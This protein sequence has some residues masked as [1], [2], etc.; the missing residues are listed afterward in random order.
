MG[1]YNEIQ[2]GR[3]NRLVQK[4]LSLKGPASLVSA[5][6]VL[7]FH[8]PLFHGKENRYLEAWE[9]FAGVAIIP[10]QGVGNLSVLQLRNDITT[11]VI[12]VVESL[13]P[14]TS[15]AAATGTWFVREVNVT[16]VALATAMVST[17]L[18]TRAR[19]NP[20]LEASFGTVAAGGAVIKA[21]GFLQPSGPQ[22]AIVNEDQQLILLPGTTLQI[23]FQTA[24]QA[25]AIGI[26]WRERALEDSER[27]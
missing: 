20:V 25:A 27:K 1:R 2:V 21:F 5:E 6:D 17:G 19:S 16:Q 12:A 22:E 7:A 15:G 10:A 4:L 26:Q 13:M 8:I 11:N 14:F 18:D 23:A 3:F 24:N 9:I